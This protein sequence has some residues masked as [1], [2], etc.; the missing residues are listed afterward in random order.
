MNFYGMHGDGA[1]ARQITR[2]ALMGRA[3]WALGGGVGATTIYAAAGEPFQPRLTRVDV[4]LAGLPPGLDGLTIAQLSDLHVQP[5]FP[6]RHLRP[7]IEL[8]NAQ[9]PDL[10]AL[11]GDYINDHAGDKLEYMAACVGE[12][13]RLQA[14]QSAFAVFG[15]HDFPDWRADPPDPPRALWEAAGITPLFDEA[16]PLFHGGATLWIA[17]LRSSL[18][19]PTWPENILRRLPASDPCLLL[20][21]EPDRAP[22]SARAGATLQLS[23]HTHGGQIRLPGGG[24]LVLPPQGRRYPAGLF[25][26]G[27]MALYVTRGVGMLPPLV[28]LNCPPEVTLLTLRRVA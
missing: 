8:A 10:I 7:A 6:A 24:P 14:R 11:T 4:P 26:V 16:V 21:H 3:A 28:R 17:G 9:R 18:V 19:R 23:G 15:N 1:I 13:T 25:R 27:A 12:L 5:G 2:R 22:E 20:W